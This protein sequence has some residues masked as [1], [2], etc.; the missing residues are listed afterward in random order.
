[1][2]EARVSELAANDLLTFA[3]EDRAFIRYVSAAPSYNMGARFT[4]LRKVQKGLDKL[5]NS[6]SFMPALKRVATAE[7]DGIVFRINLKNYGWESRQW[8][9]LVRAYPYQIVTKDDQSL[10]ILALALVAAWLSW[11]G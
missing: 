5:L 11:G 4:D 1:M 9:R 10:H 6:L 2:T 7:P 3:K 8:E